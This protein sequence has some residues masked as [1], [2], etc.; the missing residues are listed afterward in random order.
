MLPLP[1][2][3]LL[4]ETQD[5]PELLFVLLCFFDFP[6]FVPKQVLQEVVG[7]AAYS[8]LIMYVT[9]L[10]THTPRPRGHCLGSMG[11]IV[12]QSVLLF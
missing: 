1:L 7:D 12:N 8:R 10:A 3:I 2:Q 9:H 6:P 11:S 5:F 4:K